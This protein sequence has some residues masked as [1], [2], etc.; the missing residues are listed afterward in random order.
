MK[1]EISENDWISIAL[2]L[3]DTNTPA[4]VPDLVEH[5][6]QRCEDRVKNVD[7]TGWTWREVEKALRKA[8]VFKCDTC[9]DWFDTDDESSEEGVCDRCLGEA[10]VDWT[11]LDDDEDLEDDEATELAGEEDSGEISE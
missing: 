3:E 5:L 10:D 4:S 1:T 9:G 2:C 6:K 7:L 11:D 8:M